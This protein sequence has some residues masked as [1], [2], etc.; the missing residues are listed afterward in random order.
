M[1]PSKGKKNWGSAVQSRWRF[2]GLCVA[3]IGKDK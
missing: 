3:W 2:P 1:L